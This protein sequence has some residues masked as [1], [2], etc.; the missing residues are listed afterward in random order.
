MLQNPFEIDAK[1]GGKFEYTSEGRLRYVLAVIKNEKG[2]ILMLQ[3]IKHGL[4]WQCPGGK[5]DV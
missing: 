4:R 1:Q 2:E 3:N 5:I